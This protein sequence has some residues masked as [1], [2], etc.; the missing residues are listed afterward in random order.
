MD[1]LYVGD[2]LSK[3]SVSFSFPSWTNGTS[4]PRSGTSLLGLEASQPFPTDA[5]YLGEERSGDRSSTV[6]TARRRGPGWWVRKGFDSQRAGGYSPLG[7]P[8][9]GRFVLGFLETE[10]EKGE[11]HRTQSLVRCG[12]R[13]PGDG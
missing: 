2:R 7:F 8:P 9:F 6:L 13:G 11:E 1:R 4:H 12:A 5:R 3:A 10:R